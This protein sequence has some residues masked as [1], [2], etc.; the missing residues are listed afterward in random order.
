MSLFV[1]LWVMSG[2]V[3][4][5]AALVVVLFVQTLIYR[6][7]LDQARLE[8]LSMTRLLAQALAVDPGTAQRPADRERQMQDR[9]DAMLGTGRLIAAVALT[10]DQR[11]LATALAPGL[12]SLDPVL[13]FAPETLRAVA[14]GPSNELRMDAATVFVAM[15]LLDWAGGRIG[16]LVVSLPRQILLHDG[17]DHLIVAFSA[18]LLSILLGLP[19]ALALS[20]RIARPINDLAALSDGLERG[21]IDTDALTPLIGRRDEIGRLARVM[22]RLVHALNHLGASMDAI[23]ARRLDELRPR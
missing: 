7:E 16:V 11:R 5:A 6:G 14:E 8:A 20:R 22:L 10:H 9:L 18:L 17:S 3:A 1:R 23:V 2:A 13:Q 19:A 15:P 21:H 12:E 4:A